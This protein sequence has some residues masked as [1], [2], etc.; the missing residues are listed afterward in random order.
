MAISKK[1]HTFPR[2]LFLLRAGTISARLD[3]FRLRGKWK[4]AVLLGAGFFFEL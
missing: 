4:F 1:R 3:W 2:N